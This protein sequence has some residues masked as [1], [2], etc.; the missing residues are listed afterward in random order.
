MLMTMSS[1]VDDDDDDAGA[2]FVGSLT[3][4]GSF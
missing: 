1:V 2:G 3:V 4:E